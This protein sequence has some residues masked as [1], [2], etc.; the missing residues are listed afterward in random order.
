MY[1]FM[2]GAMFCYLCSSTCHVLGCCRKH[3]A[4]FIWRFDYVGITTLTVCSFYPLVHYGLLCQPFARLFYLISVTMVGVA[5]IA[6]SLL[7]VFQQIEWRTF[8]YCLFSG[9]G[10]FSIFPISHIFIHHFSVPLVRS[11]MAW[12]IVHGAQFTRREF[13]NDIFRGG[14]T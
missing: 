4:L 5:V 2:A 9:L 1:A 10:L 6:V 14:L 3:I 8:R 13:R 11:A 12:D 7:D